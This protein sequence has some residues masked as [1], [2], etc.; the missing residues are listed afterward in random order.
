MRRVEEY[1]FKFEYPAALSREADSGEE[2]P[3]RNQKLWGIVYDVVAT[4]ESA[5][6]ILILLFSLVFRPAAVIGNSMLPS[7]SDGDRVACVH[8]FSGYERGD[9][10]IISHATRKDESIIKRVIAVGGDTVDI[11][12]YKGTVSVNGQVLD[13]PCLSPS[14]IESY[15]ECPC[16]WFAQR[17][18]RL[19]D[20]DE[21]FGPL[22]MGDFAHNALHSFYKHMSEDLGEAKV[23]PQLLPQAWELM[24]DVLARHKALQPHLRQSENR[25]IPTSQVEHRE[26]AELE[27]KLM[28][29]LDFEAELL[30]TFAPK[31]LEYDVAGGGS[32]DYAGHKLLGTADRIDVDGEG[33]CAIID[34]KGSI[35]GSYALGVREEGRLGKVQALIYA[36]VVRRTLG[37][38]PVGALYV[39][40]GRRKMI[41]GAYDGRVIENAHLPNMRHKDCMCADRPFSDVLDETEEAVAAALERMLAGDIRPRPETPE[42]CK[43]CP[44]SS[45]PERRG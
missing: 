39:C 1:W 45:C 5:V 8:S 31:Y 23:T 9:V 18:L 44:V 35:S 33:R 37:L 16:K 36:Q 25:L 43:W 28:D 32:V 14:Q 22:E 42:A 11:D 12:F 20:L 17:R 24:A 38:E 26:L 7:F 41:S 27:R 34:Y 40:Y 15:L 2:L 4:L 29:Y 10:I 19:D 6:I 21:G 3:E 13:E 30:P